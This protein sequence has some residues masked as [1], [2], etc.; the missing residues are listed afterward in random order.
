MRKRK[1]ACRNRKTF[2][3]TR[4]LKGRPKTEM[5]KVQEECERKL[6]VHLRDKAKRGT[7]KQVC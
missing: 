2:K 7:R 4:I 6:R 3:A 1:S 5:I